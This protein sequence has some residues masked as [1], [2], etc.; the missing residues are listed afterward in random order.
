MRKKIKVAQ[1]QPG[2]FV[3]EFCGSWMEHPFWNTRFLVKEPAD[4]AQIVASPVREV[5][6]DTSRGL[7]VASAET[8]QEVAQRS[9][10]ALRDMTGDAPAPVQAA[11][12]ADE[13]SRASRICARAKTAVISMFQEARMGQ[14]VDA[15]RLAPLVDEISASVARN[16]GALISLARLKT[17]DDYTYLHSVA[18]C[19]L[20]LSLARQLGL[21]EAE[22]RDIGLAGLVHDIGKAAIPDEILNKPGKLT[23][24]EFGIIKTHPTMGHCMLEEGKTASAIARDVCL[25][26][27]EKV[28]GSGYPDHLDANT[29]SLYAK[30]GAVCDVYDAITSTRC[31]KPGWSPAEALRKMTEWSEGHF[32]RTVFQA[33]VKCMGIYPVGSM[34]RLESGLIAV[35]TAT[36]AQRLLT[37]TV[38]AF[39]CTRRKERL[40]PRIIDL[41]KSS[42]R[43]KIAGWESPSAWPFPDIEELWGAPAR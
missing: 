17:K 41:S 3:D 24:V 25:H 19:G 27:H 39:Y 37:P 18:V 5:W 40:H 16:P 34:V 6:I 31:Y 36:D 10:A 2:M 33:F 9:E 7:D 26:H 30:M 8:A 21:P 1:L 38:K 11:S 15:E 29:L 4:L 13:L 35:V 12:L 42:A 20:M 32:D 23:E 28:D 43:D 22:M 14:A